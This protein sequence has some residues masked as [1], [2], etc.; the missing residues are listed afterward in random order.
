[1]EVVC[2]KCGANGRDCR[3]AVDLESG[4]ISCDSCDEVYE[5]AEVE[6]VVNS[7]GPL[8]PWLKQHPALRPECV[9]V[10]AAG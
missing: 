10:K 1:M 9:A 2:L 5:V 4:T 7:W 8:L 3:I 6:A